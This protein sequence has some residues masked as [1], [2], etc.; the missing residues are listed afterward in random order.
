MSLQSSLAVKRPTFY[1]DSQF[2]SSLTS[3]DIMETLDSINC[4]EK[5]SN[6]K[7]RKLYNYIQAVGTNIQGSE[8]CRRS[9]RGE[10]QGLMVRKYNMSL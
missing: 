3:N 4:D 1:H 5:M 6:P 2:I 9:Y 10:I 8:Y 7:V